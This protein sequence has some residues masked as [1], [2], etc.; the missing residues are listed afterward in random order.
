M[1]NVHLNA[2]RLVTA[3]DIHKT[4]QHLLHLQTEAT[5]WTNHFPDKNGLIPQ[6]SYSL[7]TEIPLERTCAKAG[8][9]DPY[10]SC[11]RLE[12][13]DLGSI[14]PSAN[15]DMAVEGAMALIKTINSKLKDLLYI[16]FPWRFSRIIK[17]KKLSTKRKFM[18]VVEATVFDETRDHSHRAAVFKGWLMKQ[19]GES[20]DG[21]LIDLSDVSRRDIYGTTSKCVLQRAPSMK[22]F[23]HCRY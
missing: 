1:T 18:V 13:I 4:L 11:V 7:M 8:I 15:A 23:C 20:G 22:K 2:N 10:C 12:T 6:E 14:N 3:F 17:A 19:E 16:C 9:P 5:P 21:F